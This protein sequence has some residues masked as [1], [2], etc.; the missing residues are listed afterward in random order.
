MIKSIT[1]TNHLGES[2][3]LELTR[4]ELSGFAVEKIEGLGPVKA[5]VNNTE[6]STGDGGVFNSARLGVRNIVMDLIFIPGSHA[7]TIEDIRHRSYKYF[8]TK[9]SLTFRVETDTRILE[10]DGYVEHNDPSIFSKR[11]GCQ[12]SILCPNPYFRD[13]GDVEVT[14]FSGVE[15]AFEFEFEND[16]L[17]ENLLEMGTMYNKREK[18]I[19]YKGDAEVGVTIV[20][21]ALGEAKHIAIYNT[22]TREVMRIDTDKLEVLT[23]SGIVARDE[24]RIT[25]IDGNKS[26]TLL[27]EGITTNILNCLSRDADWF[28]LSKG[29]NLFAYTAEEGSM[30]L[31]FRIEHRP[32]YEGV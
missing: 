31:Q 16:S 12:I 15:P 28:H 30:N 2:I 14:T 29:D 20:I 6:I 4:P 32:I 19:I 5:T 7:E 21:K 26:I 11:E 18:V 9:K 27:R 22:G 1:V 3:V 17:I 25:T 23:G 8:P 10:I 13:A 24:I